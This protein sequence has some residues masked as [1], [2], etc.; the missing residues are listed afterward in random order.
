MERVEQV[1]GYE[2]HQLLQSINELGALG[3]LVLESGGESGSSVGRLALRHELLAVAAEN[4]LTPPGQA[5]LHRRIGQVLESEIADNRSTSILWDCA[6]HWQRAGNVGRGF[7]LARS[8]AMHLMKVGLCSAAAEA[9]RMSMPFCSSDNERIDMLKGEA[10]AHFG[11][12]DWVNLANTTETVRRLQAYIEP[13]NDGHDDIELMA[14]RALWQ[15]G[16]L[17]TVREK[18]L[19]CLQC[20]TAT[21]SHRVRAGVMSLMLLDLACDQ[22][23]MTRTF[24]FLEPLFESPTIDRGLLH[25]AQMVYQAA[26]GDLAQAVL[27]AQ[28]LIECSRR[29]E[30]VADLTRALANGSVAARTA[31]RIDLAKEW[32]HE[33]LSIYESHKLPLATIVPMQIL[34]SI[35]LDENDLASAR[36][37]HRRLGVFPETIADSAA[38]R[39]SIG[40]RIALCERNVQEVRRLSYGDM[41]QLRSDTNP[42]RRIY[43]TALLVAVQIA[44]QKKP[45]ADL[46]KLLETSHL[47]ARRNTRQAFAT[48]VLV[49]ALRRSGKTKRAQ[50]LLDEYCTRYRREPTPPPYHVLEL[51]E[52]F[53]SAS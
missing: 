35:A 1:L 32:L 25:E 49:T 8:C 40:L 27:H 18:A 28:L 51:L 4:T 38:V 45:D 37:W 44:E 2:H 12:S 47:V 9:Y 36:A 48:F 29:S 41:D 19:G 13:E 23:A 39:Q 3:M 42:H 34:A 17:N 46:L 10:A 24:G 26:C 11:A 43:A 14:L 31:G 20:T 33:A 22:D 30:N 7:S 6:K 53:A 52:S 15:N 5:Y 50:R 21:H 16:E